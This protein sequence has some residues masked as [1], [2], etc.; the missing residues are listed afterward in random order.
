L[1][2]RCWVSTAAHIQPHDRNAHTPSEVRN[3]SGCAAGSLSALIEVG[4]LT[5]THRQ[6]RGLEMT[7][8]PL[9]GYVRVSTSQQGL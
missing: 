8:T 3:A 6:E 7:A 9:I 2:M 4:S 5:Y 1:A